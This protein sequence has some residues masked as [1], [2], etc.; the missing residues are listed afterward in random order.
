MLDT[1]GKVLSLNLTV[2]I[3][4]PSQNHLPVNHNLWKI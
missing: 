2:V 4:I 1:Q 3:F